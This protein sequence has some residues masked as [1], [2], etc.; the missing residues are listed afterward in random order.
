MADDGTI[1]IG[2]ELDNSGLKGGLSGLGGIAKKGMAAVGSAAAGMASITVGALAAVATGMGV[3]V[4]SG[5]EYN[6]QMENYTAN[7][8]TM[9][10]SEEAAVA[11]V[12]ELKKLGAATPFE[13]SDL[14]DATTTLLAFGVSADDSTGILTML[15][16]V[17]LGNADKMQRLTN[18][19]GKAN[20]LGK[21]TG[22]TYQQ[23][24]EAGFNPLKVISD[25][26][27]ESMEQLQ[28]R[29]S[30]GG[31]S[32][33]ELTAAFKTATSEGGQ[34]YKG[35]ETASTTF[36]GLISTLKDNANSLVGEVVKPI[37]D[38]LTKTLLP[39]AIGAVST[40]TDAFAKDGIPG[41]IDA[42]GGVV[43]QIITGIAAKAPE[44]IQMAS[45]FLT[46]LLNAIV[47]QLPALQTA[48]LGIINEL[49]TAVTAN[50]PL[51]LTIALSLIMALVTGLITQLPALVS[52][53]L[54]L[55]V[56]LIQGLTDALPQLI[57][58]LRAS[59]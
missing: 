26:T 47:T 33:E 27:G 49:V 25:Q 11:K 29:M 37:S 58:M 9:L 35:M 30:K 3:A 34:F 50:L 12:N 59:S 44:V 10:G 54:D 57:E 48:G 4:K 32:A 31:I 42:A 2:T 55:L 23:M 28:D 21:M 43:G 51:L 18:A 56:S 6:A 41:L 20:S 19:F 17:S 36:D 14:A 52:C 13:M 45:G 53:G 46:T 5:I 24:V 40:L 15:G 1:K 8:K 39:Q 16:D 22:E 38:S 7:F